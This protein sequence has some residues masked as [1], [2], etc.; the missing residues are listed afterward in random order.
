MERKYLGKITNVRFGF[1]GYN[2]LMFGLSLTL[3]SNYTCVDTFIGTWDYNFLSNPPEHASWDENYRTNENIK[4][5]KR[6]SDLL[7]SAK[8]SDISQ[9]KNIP[10]EFVC[11]DNVLKNWRILEEVL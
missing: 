2:D 3:N 11:E 9:L 8:V 6:I 5:C 4:L 7:T 1:G 10:V